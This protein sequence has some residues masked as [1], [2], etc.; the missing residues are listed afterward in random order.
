MKSKLSLA[1]ETKDK[2][3]QLALDWR[4]YRHQRNKVNRI[5]NSNKT[6]Y[7]ES[8]L[9]NN[10]KNTNNK[11]T[12]NDGNDNYSKYSDKKLWNTVRN[13]TNNMKMILPRIITYYNTIIRSIKKNG[14]IT[15]NYFI[16]KIA[17]IRYNFTTDSNIT[18]MK[19]LK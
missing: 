5:N 17:K 10:I 8:R 6:K 18:P 9:N 12:S 3:L 2:L 19:I 4:I 13:L 15:N 11:H 14:G 7:C 1:S 16:N